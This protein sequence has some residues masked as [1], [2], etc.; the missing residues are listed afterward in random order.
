[1]AVKHKVVEC[2]NDY[3]QNHLYVIL[4][5]LQNISSDNGLT[6]TDIAKQC[7]QIVLNLGVVAMPTAAED[8]KKFMQDIRNVQEYL[9]KAC[10]NEE[11]ISVTLQALY[12]GIS[13]PEKQPS[14]AMSVVLQLIDVKSIPSAVKRILHNGYSDQSLERALLTLCDWLSKWIYTPNLGPLVLC[15]M[16]GLETEQH[17]DI[18][19]EVTRS[20]VEKFFKLCVLATSR[21]SVGPVV[22]YILE[23]MQH[24]P[25]AFHKIIPHTEKVLYSLAKEHS[26]T[27]Q[28]Y[29]KKFVDLFMALMDH[30]PDYPDLYDSLKRTLE[31]YEPT[32]NYKEKLNCKSW[33]STNNAMLTLVPLSGK[34]GLNNL[35]N[36]CYMNSI[37]QALFMTKLFRNSVLLSS[38]DATPLFSKLQSLFALLQFSERCS[39]SPNDLLNLA[40]PPGFQQ[41]HQHDSSEFLGYLL[42]ALHEQ[43]KSTYSNTAQGDNIQPG[44]SDFQP[45]E[46][47]VVQRSF[48]GRAVTHSHCVV[49]GSHSERADSFRELQLS[50]PTNCSNHS[51]QTLVDFYLQPE[52]LCGDNQ[53][54][55]DNCERLTDGERISKIV[56]FPAQLILTLKHFRYDPASQQRTKLLLR[57]D[58]DAFIVLENVRY[59][60]YGAVIHCGSSVDSGHY[61]TYARDEAEWFKFNDCAVFKIEPEELCKLHPPETPY[62]LFYSRVDTVIPEPVLKSQLSQ[63]LQRVLLRDNVELEAERKRRQTLVNSPLRP[64]GGGNGDPPPPGCGDGGFL[65]STHNRFVC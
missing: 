53:Y 13:D 12:N 22:I 36:T 44:S 16:Q 60:L 1:M 17:Y 64:P 15:F 8:H 65:D 18:L 45:S 26:D 28:L 24:S 51:V 32:K 38:R 33:L 54:H 62:M 57:V 55:C 48:G 42:D 47:T 21:R 30:F 9:E 11:V 20:Y 52:Q 39:L 50:I 29:L 7:E 5:A 41:G 4:R 27:S 58:L 56:Q 3:R 14:P 46:N 40:R 19:I 2:R 25:E 31:L 10:S 63:R 34:V 6:Q 59:T 49:C 37:L 43:E 61:Y 23:K 35:G